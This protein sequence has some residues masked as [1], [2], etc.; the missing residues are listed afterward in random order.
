MSPRLKLLLGFAFVVA[1]VSAFYW[2]GVRLR[3][4]RAEATRVS[5]PDKTSALPEVTDIPDPIILLLLDVSNSLPAGNDTQNRERTATETFLRVVHH[6]SSPKESG[7]SPRVGIVAFGA[8]PRWIERDGNR[9]WQLRSREDLT[10]IIDE[11]GREL[12][13]TGDGDRRRG[14]YTDFNG[15]LHEA[16]GE[17]QKMET[18]VPALVM[19]MTD[20]Q[21]IPYPGNVWN[22]ADATP[23][24]DHGAFCSEEKSEALRAMDSVKSA[25][26]A[27]LYDELLKRM[28]S[29]AYEEHEPVEYLKR[30]AAETGRTPLGNQIAQDYAAYQL[31]VNSVGKSAVPKR[32]QRNQAKTALQHGNARLLDWYV[33]QVAKC[34]SFRVIGLSPLTLQEVD[35]LPPEAKERSMRIDLERMIH[36]SGETRSALRWCNDAGLLREFLAIF[37]EWLVLLEQSAS[38]SEPIRIGG[39]VQSL[40]VVVEV[41]SETG[42]SVRLIDPK[43]KSSEPTATEA[44]LSLFL[45]RQP[46][47]G[48]Y[49]LGADS[50][51]LSG[52]VKVLI[53]TEPLFRVDVSSNRTRLGEGSP[54]A[55]IAAFETE[56]RSRV[57]LH[58]EFADPIPDLEG[59]LVDESG[60]SLR[61]VRWQPR[62]NS[63]DKVV[64]YE[65][66]QDFWAPQFA[67]CPGRYVIRTKLQG[68]KYQESGEPVTPQTLEF[69]F[70]IEPTVVVSARDADGFEHS[71]FDFP[72]RGLR[73]K[74]D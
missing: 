29:L 20:G 42:S 1:V 69:A 41:P 9:I 4:E 40:A 3:Q 25:V 73:L 52:M 24:F 27:S 22:Y 70:T 71:K 61:P 11:V 14:T 36:K 56:T 68:L 2:Y 66:A 10:R 65:L 53:Q 54:A 67:R 48:E 16:L 5:K 43:G 57:D 46:D 18:S 34:A 19:M 59:E 32:I 21:H 17:L 35:A 72:P 12:G 30:L 64:D 63:A 55:R 45:V 50:R 44:G 51:T 15:A 23:P 62:K 26:P 60:T 28:Q 47:A 13:T 58:E 31:L 33:P 6:F 8:R 37:Q 38:A 39:K 74:A 49:R 7:F